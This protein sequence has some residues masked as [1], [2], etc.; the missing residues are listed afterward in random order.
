[1]LNEVLFYSPLECLSPQETHLEDLEDYGNTLLRCRRSQS[2]RFLSDCNTRILL[3][4]IDDF[5]PLDHYF[6]QYKRADAVGVSKSPSLSPSAYKIAPMP[7][8]RTD[9]RRR[10]H[11]LSDTTQIAKAGHILSVCCFMCIF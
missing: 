4:D 5:N 8:E 11:S 9:S 1:M 7:R 6:E 10:H 3:D 2:M